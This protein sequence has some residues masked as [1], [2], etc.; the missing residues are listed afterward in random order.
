MMNALGVACDLGANDTGR[1]GIVLGA[2][3]A[4]NGVLVED[5]DFERAGR[6]TIVRTG[7]G[8]DFRADARFIA[9]T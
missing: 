3:D 5:L 9:A 8:E 6:R 1:I 7:G 4:P 2:A